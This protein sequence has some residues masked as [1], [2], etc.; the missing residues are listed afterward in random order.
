MA[1]KIEFNLSREDE[2]AFAEAFGEMLARILNL[3]DT[4]DAVHI[5]RALTDPGLLKIDLCED[6]H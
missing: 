6:E 2:G 5:L 1:Q 3:D 4:E